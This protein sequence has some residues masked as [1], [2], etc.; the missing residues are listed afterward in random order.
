MEKKFKILRFIGTVWKILAWIELVVGVLASI[1]LL[2]TGILGGSFDM[3]RQFGQQPGGMGWAF[4]A[5]GGVIGFIVAII[6]TV[7]YFLALYAI[8]ELIYLMLAIEENTRRSAQWI[9]EQEVVSPT[10]L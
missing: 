2:L 9:Q 4:G 6:L 7:I 10:S 8:G 5:V 3:M 1:G